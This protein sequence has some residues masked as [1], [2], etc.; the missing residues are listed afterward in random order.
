MK[1]RGPIHMQL[2]V[3][4]ARRLLV[5]LEPWRDRP[6]PLRDIWEELTILL[7]RRSADVHDTESD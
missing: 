7:A 4:E 5:L 6:D 2:E 3:A 1:L